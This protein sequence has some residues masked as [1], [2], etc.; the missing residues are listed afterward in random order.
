MAGM[1]GVKRLLLSESCGV[2]RLQAHRWACVGTYW[3]EM[4]AS[5][6]KAWSLCCVLQ[7]GSS[8]FLWKERQ[9]TLFDPVC[10]T[11]RTV[12]HYLQSWQ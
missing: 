9:G 6:A 3:F 5:A 7:R 4:V 1:E 8:G 12:I 2:H 10:K 11:R